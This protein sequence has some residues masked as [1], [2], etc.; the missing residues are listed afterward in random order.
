MHHEDKHPD[1]KDHTSRRIASLCCLPMDDPVVQ[2]IIQRSTDFL[3]FVTHDGF[4]QLQL[5]TYHGKERHETH[6]Y[7]FASP[8]KLASGLTCNRAASFFIYRG[9]DPQRGETCFHHLYP[10]PKMRIQPNSVTST[11]T[12]DL[13]LLLSLVQEMRFF[14]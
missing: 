11:A 2:C 12:M 5:V 13:E 14:G 3:G 9:D 10:T 7:W 4:K 1:Q 8:P 6:H